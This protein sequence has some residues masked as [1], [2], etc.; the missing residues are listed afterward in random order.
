MLTF[1]AEID[2]ITENIHSPD[3]QS[4]TPN[5]VYMSIKIEFLTH[6]KINIIRAVAADLSIS[7]LL[8]THL[9]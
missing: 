4:N 3:I 9:R 6:S 7:C 5:F 1:K 8:A 2:M